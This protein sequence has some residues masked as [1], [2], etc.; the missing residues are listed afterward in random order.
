MTTR[1][2]IQPDDG[3]PRHGSSGYRYGC[4]CDICRACNRERHRQWRA[5]H[6]RTASPEL[7]HGTTNV[8]N[9]YDCRCDLCRQAHNAA[10]RKLRMT[11]AR[12]IVEATDGAA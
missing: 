11:R 8:Y 9:N 4:R 3:D 7:R 6:D 1:A 5:E 2:R 12:R 10:A